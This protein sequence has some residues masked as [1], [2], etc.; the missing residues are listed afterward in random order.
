MRARFPSQSPP[1][2]QRA[3]QGLARDEVKGECQVKIRTVWERAEE[4]TQEQTE[5][6]TGVGGGGHNLAFFEA[7][8]EA[9]VGTDYSMCTPHPE[10]GAASDQVAAGPSAQRTPIREVREEP[11]P[12][13]CRQGGR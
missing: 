2:P 1:G 13:Y 3:Q 12:G 11:L 6:T 9:T 4:V 5:G 7:G 10:D 8:S